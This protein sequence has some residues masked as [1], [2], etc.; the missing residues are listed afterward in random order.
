MNLK[1]ICL[2]AFACA[3]LAG[4]ATFGLGS[5]AQESKSIAFAEVAVTG[6]AQLADTA[7]KNGWLKG[8]KAAE[9][10]A[11]LKASDAA[12]DAAYAAHAKGDHAAVAN[13]LAVIATDV[14]AIKAAAAQP[15]P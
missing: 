1:K 13:Q 8:Q 5:A 12:L 11:L 4:C 10:S 15:S 3:A 14:V 9:A 7:V 6:A 2:A